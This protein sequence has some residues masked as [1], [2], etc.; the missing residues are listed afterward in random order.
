MKKRLRLRT[1]TLNLDR[2]LSLSLASDP[3]WAA[4]GEVV[5][6]TVTAA[7][8]LRAPLPG[9]VL[10]ATLPAG[11][12]YVAKSAVGFTYAPKDK[13]LTWPVG[14]L[15]AG[16]V[17]TGSFQARVQ[18]PA[19]GETITNTVT[20]TSPAL[21][22]GV[23]ARPRWMWSSPR[24]NEAWVTPDDGRHA[25]DNGRPGAAAHP[26]GRGRGAGALHLPAAGGR[27]Q[28]T[29]WVAVRLPRGGAG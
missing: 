24:N 3:P 12:V 21:A 25:A 22:A 23:T 13:Q 15:A 5:T 2:N 29:G 18:G 4:P 1:K 27:A 10:T 14:E 20:A 9:L 8:L 19:I 6:F 17:I 16:A 28:P 26:A 11:L 7:N